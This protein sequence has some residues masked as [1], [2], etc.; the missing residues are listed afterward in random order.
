MSLRR[1]S[2]PAA[3][4]SLARP[5]AGSPASSPR[6]N[7]I[8]PRP[9]RFAADKHERNARDINAA[10][11]HCFQLADRCEIIQA[12]LQDPPPGSG[13]KGGA[14]A[15]DARLR[16]TRFDLASELAAFTSAVAAAVASDASDNHRAAMGLFLRAIQHGLQLCKCAFWRVPA[17][18]GEGKEPLTDED[19]HKTAA[20]PLPS[21]SDRHE[22]N[23][24]AVDPV[25]E[26]C[27]I[28]ADRCD[29]IRAQNR[30]SAGAC[31]TPA[32]FSI[33]ATAATADS[34]SASSSRGGHS[35][36]APA[37]TPM[38][39]APATS[40][41][42]ER[43]VEELVAIARSGCVARS[44]GDLEGALIHYR[45]AFAAA[46][47]LSR[48]SESSSQSLDIRCFKSRL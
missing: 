11:D 13:G 31:A 24:S 10:V 36:F 8:R 47:R 37:S 48:A 15:T 22:G 7:C 5:D 23:A 27:F 2:G 32:A 35:P 3:L 6:G 46:N 18:K 9:P 34:A 25:V 45:R 17:R 29:E 41:A 1:D 19:D 38:G 21:P 43:M 28:L 44:R 20:P 12:H 42:V 40:G 30:S 39:A 16:E 14:R 4:V 26:Q 33:G